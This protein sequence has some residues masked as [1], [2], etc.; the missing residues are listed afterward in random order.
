MDRVLQSVTVAKNRLQL[1]AA[2]CFLLA[3]KYEEAEENIP[4]AADVSSF[5]NNAYPAALINEFEVLILE[6]LGWKCTVITPL[7]YLGQFAAEVTWCL[8]LLCPCPVVARCL[9][10]QALVFTNDTIAG[11]PLV[12]KV[13]RYVVKYTNFFTDMCQQDYSFARYPP[14]LLAAAIVVASRRALNIT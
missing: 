3:A 9:R 12:P 1:I 10:S 14:S 5:C 7:T 13:P 2:C 6:R 11:R 4:S 8:G